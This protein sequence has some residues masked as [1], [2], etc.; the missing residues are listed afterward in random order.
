MPAKSCGHMVCRLSAET[1]K[2]PEM[3]PHFGIFV[4]FGQDTLS[5]WES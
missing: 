4:C 1:N 2:N 3:Q 5:N